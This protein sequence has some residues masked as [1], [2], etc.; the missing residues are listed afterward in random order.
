MDGIVIGR[1]LTSNALLVYNPQNKQYYEPDSYH[2]DSYLLPTSIY[3]D[4]K[5]GGGLFCSLVCDDNPTMEEKYPP[6]TWVERMDPSTNML[7]AGTVMDIPLP[8]DDSASTGP[9]PNR[10]YS[11]LFDNGTTAFLPLSEMAGVIPLPPV[12]SSSDNS[13]NSTESLLPLFLRLN[14]RITYKHNGQYHKGFLRQC[15]R[16]YCFVFKSHVNKKKEDWG[17]DLPNLPITWVDLCVEGIFVPGHV[18]HSF[19]RPPVSLSSSTFNPVTSFVSAVNLHNDCP[20][21][22]IRALADTHPD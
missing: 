1:S 2:L 15:D 10:P 7:L 12:T 14:S 19:L 21:T 11:I 17:V 8:I 6:E 9:P 13:S 22:L 16:V 3:P 20:P 4:M 5:Y 18:S